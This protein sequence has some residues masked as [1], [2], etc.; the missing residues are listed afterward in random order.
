[1]NSDS[2]MTLFQGG[3]NDS[4]L[5]CD[6]VQRLEKKCRG[7]RLAVL[8]SPEYQE[9]LKLIIDF[10]GISAGQALIMVLFIYYKILNKRNLVIN[11]ITEWMEVDL[12][13]VVNI[14][15]DINKLCVMGILRKDRDDFESSEGFQLSQRAF[16]SVL[17]ATPFKNES[18][19]IERNLISV[20]QEFYNSYEMF[21]SDMID[22]ESL[23]DITED[24]LENNNDIKEVMFITDLDLPRD[25]LLIF[26]VV[27]HATILKDNEEVNVE[28]IIN[29]LKNK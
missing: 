1:M 15:R 22:V 5:L 27:I 18:E 7:K 8:N 10:F 25:E 21:R 26:M 2:Q 14:I 11:K 20:I 17:T 28:R 9:D 16:K 24:L 12:H 19:T 13:E 3:G 23:F 29:R 4:R 6:A